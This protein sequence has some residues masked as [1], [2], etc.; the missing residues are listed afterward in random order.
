MKRKILKSMLLLS[1]I[2]A[3]L[4][5]ALL[6][7]AFY[8]QLSA[9]IKREMKAQA[10][11]IAT[12]I[13][14]EGI[15]YLSSLEMQN[16]TARIT[17]I[18]EYGTV[19]F[20][21]RASA[22]QM[23]NHK[24]RP[25]ILNA[26]QYGDG[27]AVRMSDTIGSQT[28]YIALRLSDESILRISNTT[29]TFFMAVKNI[30]PY[31]ALMIVAILILAFFIAGFQTRKIVEPINILNLEDP[32]E[33]E[34]YEELS[35]LLI[36]IHHQRKHI[37]DQMKESERKK[38]QFDEITENMAEGLLVLDARGIVLS[39][40]RSALRFFDADDIDYEGKHFSILNRDLSLQRAVEATQAGNSSEEHFESRQNYY[41]LRATPVLENEEIKG[42][43]LLIFD[44]TEK[45]KTEAI[46]RE[47]T[48]NVSHELKTPLTSIVGS[49]E[50]L[51]NNMV[52]QEDISRFAGNIHKEATRMIALINDTIKL[53]ELDEG[54]IGGAWEEIDLYTITK[55]VCDCLSDAASSKNVTLAIKEEHIL[56]K[57]VR[58]I[59]WEMIYNLV[60]N[61]IKYNKENGTVQIE[62]RGNAEKAEFTIKDTGIGIASQD[63]DRVFER[64]YRADKSH[65]STVTGTG[66]GLSIVKH[67][68]ALHGAD[69]RIDSKPGQ[70]TRVTVLWPR[71]E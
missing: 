11:C 7:F 44:I 9:E 3:L 20:D 39:V 71:P 59:I 58:Q 2:T 37:E 48:A 56:I 63:I 65:S 55:D 34:V 66:L 43:I 33:H 23:D 62:I 12:G 40:N 64:F 35:P 47:F 69:V 67:G 29:D 46:R 61:A 28:Y 30:V 16:E 70:G 4:T 13:E 24:D 52:Q 26:S 17:L 5:A 53:S 14:A 27:E 68:A 10:V 57:G 45:Q 50:M 1:L 36:R 22:E 21:N 25:E 38:I 41:Q 32:T 8:H 60:D 18:D 54:A 51:K 19:L 42:S 31:A 49:S 6:S 15:D